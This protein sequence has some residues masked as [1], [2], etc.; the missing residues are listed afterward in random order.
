M[1]KLVLCLFLMLGVLSFSERFVEECKILSSSYSHMR[2]QSL[3]SG[4]I[5]HFS[6]PRNTLGIGQV[7]KVWF[8]GSGYRNLQLS[9]FEYLY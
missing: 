7:Y 2:C 4:K 1:K 8:T 5:F 9:Y 6:Y 3:D